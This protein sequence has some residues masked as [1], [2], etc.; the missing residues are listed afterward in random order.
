MKKIKKRDFFWT[1]ATAS[2]FL[3]IIVMGLHSLWQIQREKKALYKALYDQGEALVESLQS[4][5]KNAIISNKVAQ[6]ILINRLLDNAGLIDVLIEQTGYNSFL[7]RE[8]VAKIN[9]FAFK[10][11]IDG[12]E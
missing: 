1:Y 4:S 7:L 12:E 3:F 2:I 11:W 6:D 9:C 5:G 8:I 10:Y